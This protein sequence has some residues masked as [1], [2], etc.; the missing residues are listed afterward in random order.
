V[1]LGGFTAVEA[2]TFTM[3]ARSTLLLYFAVPCQQL[4][5]P[6]DSVD[7]AGFARRHIS[8]NKV[9]ARWTAVIRICTFESAFPGRVEFR[10]GG[11]ARNVAAIVYAKGV[12]F[13]GGKLAR[14][15]F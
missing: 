14:G 5:A 12:H 4:V 9:G 11:E 13:S 15:K 3:L 1:V 7:L 6:P 2:L 8:N 10:V